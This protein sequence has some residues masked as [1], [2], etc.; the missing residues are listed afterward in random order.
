[1]GQK[2]Y[3]KIGKDK[4]KDLEANPDKIDY[5]AVIEFYQGVIKKERD[6]VEEDKKKKVRDVELWNRAQREEEK[7]A[8]EKYAK[9]NGEKEM[10]QS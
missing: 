3:K 7:L 10:E 9:Q 5:D 8:I 4:I 2:G 1:M 6:Q